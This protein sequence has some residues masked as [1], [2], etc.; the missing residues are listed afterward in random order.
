MN[1]CILNAA[2]SPLPLECHG[3]RHRFPT[4]FLKNIPLKY[5]KIITDEI[6]FDT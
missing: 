3:S 4:F 1:Y 5:T 6:Y 2:Y